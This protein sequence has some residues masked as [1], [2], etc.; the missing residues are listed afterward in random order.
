MLNLI[1]WLVGGV[2]SLVVRGVGTMDTRHQDVKMVTAMQL[3]WEY[4]KN[5]AVLVSDGYRK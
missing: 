3:V 1:L 5:R 2:L 4:I